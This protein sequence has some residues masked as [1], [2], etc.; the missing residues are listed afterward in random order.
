[1]IN[2]IGYSISPFQLQE[3]CTAL[4]NIDFKFTIN[5]PSGNFFYEPWIIKPEFKNTIWEEILKS[6]PEIKGEARL[7]KLSPGTCYWAHADIDD[8]WHLSLVNKKS[9][10]VD[11]SSNHM[12]TTKLG[13]WYEMD[14]GKLHSAV[15]FG[16]GDRIQLVVRKLLINGRFNNGVSIKIPMPLLDNARS[17]FDETYSPWLNRMNKVGAIQ[18]FSYSDDGVEFTLHPDFV[19]NL[20]QL[21]DKFIIIQQQ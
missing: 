17:L 11:I 1:M 15:N 8:R 14:A 20:K 7:I 21:S 3:A 6:L 4:P 9:F 12:H 18:N 13:Q 2:Q 19:D 10:L 16:G 5:Q